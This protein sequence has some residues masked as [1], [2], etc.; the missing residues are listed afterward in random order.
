MDRTVAHLIVAVGV[1]KPERQV[2]GLEVPHCDGQCK[3]KERQCKVNER[4]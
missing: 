4:Q 3:V 2:T 1:V